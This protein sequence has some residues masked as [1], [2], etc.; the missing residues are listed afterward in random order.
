MFVISR[1]ENVATKANT[2]ADARGALRH[3]EEKSWGNL[4]LTENNFFAYS[5]SYIIQS[6]VNSSQL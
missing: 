5:I 1:C 4:T 3:V 2:A 6:D